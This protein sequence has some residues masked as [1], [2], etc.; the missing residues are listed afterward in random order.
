MAQPRH[1]VDRGRARARAVDPAHGR[2]QRDVEM[3]GEHQHMDGVDLV[4]AGDGDWRRLAGEVM[5][6]FEC[7]AGTDAGRT[8]SDVRW[9]TDS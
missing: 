4:D 7:H 3:S 2:R 8:R 1:A 5:E 9:P 6:Q